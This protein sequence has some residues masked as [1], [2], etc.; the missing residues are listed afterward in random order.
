MG[1][2][3]SKKLDGDF[4]FNWEWL[5]SGWNIKPRNRKRTPRNLRTTSLGP[6]VGLKIGSSRQY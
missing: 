4:F 1:I 6:K 3:S 5:A 2:Y